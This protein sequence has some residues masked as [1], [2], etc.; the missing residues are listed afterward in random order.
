VH[1]GTGWARM[2]ISTCLSVENG[3]KNRTA[4]ERMFGRTVRMFDIIDI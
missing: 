4:P 2:H 1:V 3:G